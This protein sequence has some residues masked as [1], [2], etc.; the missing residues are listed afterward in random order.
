MV[1]AA[2]VLGGVTRMTVSLV[3]IMFELTGNVNFI[4]PLM[5]AIMTA[6]WVGD[7]LGNQGVYDAHI[8]LNDYPF[9]DNKEEFSHTT[10]ASD[11]MR[12]KLGDNHL[13]VIT[14][15]SMTVS[16]IVSMLKTKS[17]AGF[18]VVVSES[19]HYLVGFVTRN[20]LM[21]AL[22]KARRTE[23]VYDHS[24]V[25]FRSFTLDEQSMYQ[26][27]TSAAAT[28]TTL[29]RDHALYISDHRSPSISSAA[30]N[31]SGNH[32]TSIQP[33]PINFR[34]IVDL[35]PITVTDQTPMETVIDMFRKLGLR[36]V[37]VTHNG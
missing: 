36:Q 4:V 12:P 3:V 9:L 37:L 2:A 6:K 27:S 8:G 18:P 14:E 5:A 7:A 13:A 32:D 10:I 19:S 21:A 35:A 24:L 26:R 20:D 1:G 11:A 34:R 33:N 23:D 15:D 31:L 30:T 25:Y 28:A 22:N 17:H 16:D 29:G